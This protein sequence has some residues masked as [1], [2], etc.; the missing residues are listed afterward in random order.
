LR[1]DF[2]QVL[3]LQVVFIHERPIFYLQGGSGD[4]LL[5]SNAKSRGRAVAD[6]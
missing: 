1:Q 3:D 2:I 5:G 4:Q 6:L